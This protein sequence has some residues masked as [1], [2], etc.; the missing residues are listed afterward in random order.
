MTEGVYYTDDDDFE[1]WVNPMLGVLLFD[2]GALDFELL[3]ETGGAHHYLF[4]N[5]ELMMGYAMAFKKAAFD[6]KSIQ[7]G[8]RTFEEVVVEYGGVGDP[9]D[10]D[11]RLTTADIDFLNEPDD[12]STEGQEG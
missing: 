9:S 6:C 5:P 7:T 10:M 11:S 1:V 2:D 3:G 4:N 12:G 8:A